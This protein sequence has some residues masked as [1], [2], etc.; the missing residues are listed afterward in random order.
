MTGTEKLYYIQ[1]SLAYVGNDLLWWAKEDRGYTTD[2]DRAGLYTEKQAKEIHRDRSS[3]VPWLATYI[4]S[5][6]QRTVDMQRI[7]L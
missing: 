4:D 5:N 7:Q 6:C 1:N 3:D 2:L